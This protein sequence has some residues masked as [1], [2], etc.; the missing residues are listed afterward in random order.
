MN[1]PVSM[2]NMILHL[3]VL[4]LVSSCSDNEKSGID[5]SVVDCFGGD[6]IELTFF[7]NDQ[8]ILE[9]E[10]NTEIEIIQ[11]NENADFH[12][13]T[14]SNVITL[15]LLDDDPITIRIDNQELNMEISSTFVEGECC[16]GIK[17]DNLKID[18]SIICENEEC[19]E[20]IQIKI[21]N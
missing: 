15:F 4:I 7:K 3:I 21:N 12:I 14:V 9:I 20:I 8:N 13:N 10:P 11:S 18:G 2:K 17:V 19:S 1:N 5:C 16:S 6:I